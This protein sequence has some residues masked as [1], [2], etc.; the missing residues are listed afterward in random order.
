MCLYRPKLF[1]KKK[2]IQNYNN[3]IL[4]MNENK[5]FL[6]SDY[7][8]LISNLKTYNLLVKN[9][10]KEYFENINLFIKKETKYKRQAV[11]KILIF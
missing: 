9:L 1:I 3:L 2:G 11:P 7:Q 6:E 10:F 4:L 5:L 8:N